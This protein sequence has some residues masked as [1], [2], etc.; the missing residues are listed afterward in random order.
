VSDLR[1][2]YNYLRRVFGDFQKCLTIVAFRPQPRQIHSLIRWLSVIAKR[3]LTQC[4]TW[5]RQLPRDGIAQN[6]SWTRPKSH[7]A[8]ALRMVSAVIL[9]GLLVLSGA[10]S[11]QDRVS[12]SNAKFCRRAPDRCVIEAA[13]VTAVRI[14]DPE[15][16][17]EHTLDRLLGAARPADRTVL[18]SAAATRLKTL[19]TARDTYVDHPSVSTCLFV[20]DYVYVFARPGRP[21]LYWVVDMKCRKAVLVEAADSLEQYARAK[22]LTKDAHLILKRCNIDAGGG[23]QFAWSSVESCVPG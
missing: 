11:A 13:S 22:K 4:Q 20:P 6:T 3:H 14:V 21:S 18:S 12:G 5:A 9:S 1:L 10:V 16:L 17:G 7:A 15:W 2:R 8:P 19:T 23:V